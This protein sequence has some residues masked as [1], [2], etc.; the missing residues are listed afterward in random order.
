[1]R[2]LS[3]PRPVQERC[4]ALPADQREIVKRAIRAGR[5]KGT[6]AVE[7]EAKISATLDAKHKGRA[8]PEAKIAEIEKALDALAA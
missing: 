2:G 1:M 8:L 6:S 7:I 3:L 5:D 4:Q